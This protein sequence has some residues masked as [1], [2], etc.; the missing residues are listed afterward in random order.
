MVSG[1]FF[2]AER[3]VR[4]PFLAGSRSETCKMSFFAEPR[5]LVAQQRAC[6]MV[7]RRGS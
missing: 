7:A 5:I 1:S 2:R 4:G 6:C 3:G